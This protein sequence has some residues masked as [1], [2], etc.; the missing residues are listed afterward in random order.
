MSQDPFLKREADR[1]EYPIPS[2]EYILS[3]L[4][5]R[6]APVSREVLAIDMGLTGEER[7]E[8]LR[9]RLRAM[10]RDGQLIFTRRQC[11]A[12]PERLDLLRGTIIGH[13]DGYGFL[14]I[15]GSKDDLYLS[16][17]QMK[18]V[19]HGD[20]V[21]AQVLGVDRKTRREA[22]IVRILVPKTSQI[23]GRFF[24]ADGSGFVVPT[25]SRLSFDILIPA[26]DTCGACTGCIVVVEMTQRSTRH[27]KAFGKIVEILGDKINTSMAVDIALR[28]YEIPYNWPFQVKKQVSS[29][30]EQV[31]EIIKKN[32]IDLRKL[33]LVTIDGEDAQDFDDA[34]CC[35]KK[36]GG[37]WRLWVAIADV[38]YYVRPN[39]A[40]D[41][42][43]RNRAT[44]VYFPS[45]VIPM[46]P[47]VLSNGL[48][49]LNPGVDRLCM[50]CE[51]TLSTQ[52]RLSTTKF[53]E[54]VINSHAR[55]TYNNVW[56]IL[57]GDQSLREHYQPLVPHLEELYAMYKVLNQ[58]RIERGS[59][60]FETEEAKFIFNSELRIDRVEP[61]AR[62]DAHKIIEECMI[63]ANI[64]AARFVEKHEEPALFR[65]HDRPSD[66]HIC[67][68]RS[69]LSELGLTLGGGTKPQPKDYA[70]LMEEVSARPDYEMLQTMLLR[71]MKQATY[72][73]KNRG[74]FGLALHSYGHFTSPIRRYPDLALHRSIKYQLAKKKGKLNDNATPTGGWHSEFEEMLQLGAH[75][76]IAERRADEAARNV[77]DWLKCDYMQGHIGEVFSGIIASVTGFGFFVRLNDLFIDGLVH[78]SS[79]YNDYYRYDN[80]GQRLMGESSGVVYR[81]GDAVKIRV[82]A[83][84]MDERKIDLTLVYSGRK[85]RSLGKNERLRVK[86]N[87]SEQK[88]I[89]QDSCSVG[90]DRMP[91]QR[92]RRRSRK[93][94]INSNPESSFCKD[95][96]K[97]TSRVKGVTK[98]K[99]KKMPANISK[100]QR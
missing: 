45:Q 59:I 51:M 72:D 65:V 13:R 29:I 49:S 87:D 73:P 8:A 74:H 14:R 66:E 23:V 11:Y 50:V 88:H 52:G 7:L 2:R 93:I 6:E 96:D 57:E 34:V 41:Q 77:A 47:E 91:T 12:L 26:D 83:V 1:Y 61:T 27:T 36:R 33:P 3:Y 18:L 67:G 76:S 16:A 71:S 5:K 15:E 48:C 22:R 21:L 64:A 99:D 10:E 25:D 53:Y 56:R 97:N 17:E 44:S 4:A 19:I 86:N 68:L 63:M 42:E 37:G 84:H 24:L 78:V 60:A 35:E 58:A 69:V 95:K 9:R 85:S 92:K 20:L 62:H 75:C 70:T 98:I 94:P 79:L 100:Q 55:L 39:T 46:L 81:L 31:P 32:C 38:S 89:L 80:I 54:A 90:V 40:L 30:N 82:E 28:N 43:A